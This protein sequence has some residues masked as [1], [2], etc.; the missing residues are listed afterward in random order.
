MDCQYAS[1]NGFKDAFRFGCPTVPHVLQVTLG[2]E[3]GGGLHGHST[4]TGSLD[5]SD[6]HLHLPPSPGTPNLLGN[7]VHAGWSDVLSVIRDHVHSSWCIETWYVD[8]LRF[9][10]SASPRRVKL[11]RQW[12]LRSFEQDCRLAWEDLMIPEEFQWW[13]VQNSHVSSPVVK[14]RIIIAHSLRPTQTVSLLH[15]EGFPVMNRYKAVCFEDG[16]LA[17]DLVAKVSTRLQ[18]ACA[19]QNVRCILE[20]G[21]IWD[22]RSVTQEQQ[23]WIHWP[24]TISAKIM[25][26]A[27]ESSSEGDDNSVEGVE[28]DA[29]VASTSAPSFVES[30]FSADSDET[31]WMTTDFAS[32]SL[33][34]LPPVQG[35][36]PQMADIEPDEIEVEN[37]D[38]EAMLLEHQWQTLVDLHR[39]M[40]EG[41]DEPGIQVVTYGLGL[42]GL[43]KRTASVRSNDVNVVL[44]AVADLWSDQAQ[45]APLQIILVQPQP[46]P[47]GAG[48]QIVFIVEVQ[49]LENHNQRRPC[50]VLVQETGDPAMVLEESTY[51]AWSG[52]RGNRATFLSSIHRDD[53][54]FPNGVRDAMVACAGNDV[55]RNRFVEFSEGNLCTVHFLPFPQHVAAAGRHVWNAGQLFTELRVISETAGHGLI[56]CRF[57]GVS[58][59]NRPLGF[60]TLYLDWTDLHEG[61]WYDQARMLWPFGIDRCSLVFSFMEF[62]DGSLQPDQ[63]VLHFVANFHREE[64]QVPVLIRQT[65]DSIHDNG[66]HSEL[67]AV[68][69]DLQTEPSNI[70]AALRDGVFW[71]AFPERVHVYPRSSAQR[72]AIGSSF[73][74][75]LHTHEKFN[76][77]LFLLHD[78][79]HDRDELEFESMSL[80]QTRVRTDQAQSFAEICDAL[81]QEDLLD[82]LGTEDNS[83]LQRGIHVNCML[84]EEETRTIPEVPLDQEVQ[85]FQKIVYENAEADKHEALHK[86]PV[87]LCLEA[88]LPGSNCSLVDSNDLSL[89]LFTRR[90]WY[91][92]AIKQEAPQILPLPDGLVVKPS[93]YH[94]LTSHNDWVAVPTTH[95]VFVDGSSNG[96][97]A[98]WS[99]VVIATDGWTQSLV[100]CAFGSVQLDPQHEHWYGADAVDNIGAELTALVMAQNWIFK[101]KD[102]RYT[103]IC[104][105]LLLS[106][107]LA[108]FQ[109][110][111]KTHPTLVRLARIQA[112]WIEDRTQYVHV[113]GHD[114]HAWNELADSLAA[115]ALKTMASSQAEHIRD[116]HL[117]ATCE[118]ELKWIWM[119]DSTAAFAP[120][121]PPLLDEQ[122]IAFPLSC[123]RVNKPVPAPKSQCANKC[124]QLKAITA[125]VLALDSRTECKEIGRA[126]SERTMRL[127]QQWKEIGAHIVGLQETR[128]DAGRFQSDNFHILASGADRTHTAVLGCELWFSKSLR[129]CNGD[130]DEGVKLADC[131]PVVQHADPRR[132]LVQFSV[133]G[134]YLNVAVLHAPCRKGNVDNDDQHGSDWSQQTSTLLHTH[135]QGQHTILLI[136]ANAPLASDDTEFFGMHGAESMNPAG[137]RFEQMLQEHALFVPSTMSWCHTGQTTT[138]SHPRG[139]KLRRDYVVVSEGLYQMVQ[140]SKVLVDHDTTFS[141]EDHLPV[142]LNLRGWIETQRDQKRVN[143]DFD[144]MKD[145]LICAQFQQALLTLPLPTWDVQ[146]DDHCRIFEEQVRQLGRQFFERKHK[147]RKRPTLTEATLHAIAFKRSCLDF[148]RK[149]GAIH[150]PDFKNQLREIEKQVKKMVC[151]DTRKFFDGLLDSMDDALGR[152]DFKELF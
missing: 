22:V 143:W 29:D 148:G 8:S 6:Q 43:G 95:M 14:L 67:W 141:H 127:D 113:K 64:N 131:N 16:I 13:V 60:R 42:I 108:K 136:D 48:D 27:E 20:F 41:R 75:C 117:L 99:F 135:T 32:L 114:A 83:N 10:V 123:R 130:Q 118:E 9:P 56:E 146:V 128:T 81:L 104:P 38:N 137:H 125:N 98:T 66:L 152:G 102:P 5:S 138:W 3:A 45:F 26:L 115:F 121:F 62:R 58:P 74:L 65:I 139:C 49:Y 47:E 63:F 82:D 105:D 25:E 151:Q 24:T 68:C 109:T 87:T 147:S 19:R 59:R 90:N 69:V 37:D 92:F 133:L 145:P 122:A 36:F 80:L 31:S 35:W 51:A 150:D 57:H 23:V 107:T 93:T 94:A 129:V 106:K 91:D 76:I 126:N 119:Q 100:G 46:M 61:V 2:E 112:E 30:D 111:T 50:P 96:S 77:L 33:Q 71:T 4:D 28:D 7:Q 53:G 40:V 73:D 11:N 54:V 89:Q 140:E 1:W 101:Q 15:C 124:F 88:V 134:A 34:P 55:P 12:T 116:M 85:L 142:M 120:C 17:G 21:P 52:F 72:V 79:A 144:R 86:A 132:L 44:A 78:T 103:I 84:Q 18:I 110:L 39:S 70:V 97:S 149:T